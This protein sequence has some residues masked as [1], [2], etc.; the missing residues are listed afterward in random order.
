[1]CLSLP[2][3]AAAMDESRNDGRDSEGRRDVRSALARAVKM[4]LLIFGVLLGGVVITAWLTDDTD[5]PF[6]YE[7]FD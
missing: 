3:L 5:L 4:T 1:M 6:D 2:I 7:G